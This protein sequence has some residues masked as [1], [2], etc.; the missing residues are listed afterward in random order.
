MKARK[1]ILIILVFAAVISG[2]IVYFGVPKFYLSPDILY[3]K[4]KVMWV[5]AGHLFTDPVSGY[6]TFHPPYYHLI[7][8]W[9]VKLGFGLDLLLVAISIIN[10]LL[11]SWFGFLALREVFDDTTA[12][13]T[14][15]LLPVINYFL[16]PRYLF[17]ASSFSFSVPF[18]LLGLWLYLKD[19][20]TLREASAALAWGIAF[21]LSPGYFFLIL[22]C[23]IYELLF[24]R[25]YRR[26]IIMAGV[27]LVAII[28]FLYQA[29]Y[30]SAAGLTGTSVFAFWRGLPGFSWLV[31]LISHFLAPA[32]GVG[33]DWELI[34]GIPILI[35][36]ILAYY[37][38]SNRHPFPAMAAIAYILTYYHYNAQYAS[39][40]LF[41]LFLFLTAYAVHWLLSANW[42]RKLAYLIC[43]VW[44]AF[45]AAYMSWH[46]IQ[47]YQH[48][49]KEFVGYRLLTERMKPALEE[50]LDPGSFILAD[51]GIYL[52]NIMTFVP[53]HALVAY[54]SGEYF[55]LN[56]EISSEM[57]TDYDSLMT[58]IDGQR[59]D[60]LCDKYGIRKAVYRYGQVEFPVFET[61]RKDWQILVDDEFF[62]IYQRR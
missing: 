13:L 41:I 1:Q 35:I 26:F 49:T 39:R 40:I 23:F 28:P 7:L 31:G 15:L 5:G 32:S 48:R 54:Y 10:V 51:A 34:V 44:I 38:A 57:R 61:I 43:A 14:I 37:R 20:G 33:L 6:P 4:A 60:S 50:N 62:K 47:Y 30:L 19:K 16:G 42:N 2:P 59:I 29:Y 58:S 22:L 17:L 52:A 45:G 21:L 56:T 24:R 46:S 8:S 9:L 25:D 11:M 53:V 12:L 36:G 18:Y 3:V 55:Q 27:F